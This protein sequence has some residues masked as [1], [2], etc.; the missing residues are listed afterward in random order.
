[1]IAVHRS[2]REAVTTPTLALAVWPPTE[3][4]LR[5]VTS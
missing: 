3:R 4:R 1:M 2:V 5:L